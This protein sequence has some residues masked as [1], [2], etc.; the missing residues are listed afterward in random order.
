M[1]KKIKLLNTSIYRKQLVCCT[2]VVLRNWCIK[3]LNI[4]K[5][6]CIVGIQILTRSNGPQRWRE[7]WRSL[8]NLSIM[9]PHGSNS[10]S[11]HHLST[12][13]STDALRFR[14]AYCKSGWRASILFNPR[15]DFST[16][17]AQ[18]RRARAQVKVKPGTEV[19][20][21]KKQENQSSDHIETKKAVWVS[22][23]ACRFQ[24]EIRFESFTPAEKNALF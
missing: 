1:I 7:L 9:S 21:V 12:I 3:N 10:A 17:K 18:R 5:N 8:K 15:G 6:G 13:V 24:A 14:A 16:K 20:N 2:D 22:V 11:T 19:T 4:N 23:A